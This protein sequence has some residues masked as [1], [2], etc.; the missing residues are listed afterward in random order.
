MLRDR[1]DYP[2]TTSSQAARDA[3][4]EA[5]DLFL[6]SCF[7]VE[8]AV[9]RAVEADPNLALA[10]LIA[11]RQH[12]SMGRRAEIAAPLAA[13][14]AATGLTEREASQVDALGA[15]LEGRAA[16]AM[17]KVR[18]HLAIWPRDAMIAQTAVGVFGLIGFSGQEGREAEQLAFTAALLPHYGDDWWMLG[19]HAFSQL[20]AGRLGE[21]ERNIERSLAL[22]PDSGQGA[23]I[24][25]HLYYE[26]G[27]T[28]AGYGYLRDWI[29]GYD[30]R[31]LLHTHISWHVALWALEQG[32]E[33]TLWSVTEADIA[34]GAA[35]GPALN[36]LTDVAAIL[37]RAELAGVTPPDGMWAKTSAYAASMFP[38]PGLAF[39]DLHAAL[40]HAMAGEGE[41][42]A[43]VIDGARGP[44]G[45][46]VSA[47]G[48]ALG[49]FAAGRWAEAVT[50][51]TPLMGAHERFGGSRAQRDLLEFAFAAALLRSGSAE[52]A[53]RCIAMRRRRST[54]NRAIGGLWEGAAA[55][56]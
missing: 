56:G 47:A 31:G 2:L 27:E 17:A 46:L 28:A 12:Q 18:A 10:H 16:E 51:L 55:A 44:A 9:A 42:L 22:N 34:P 30:R 52:E 49:E 4:Q 15:L 25:S 7:G 40:A 23:H 54:S 8:D 29:G 39:A 6:A 33:A 24:R 36:V 45:D 11:A 14:R 53:R 19:G 21:A 1:Y 26:N 38:K 48:V 32:D 37:F 13:A 5:M 50:L 35:S 3:C 43:R 20:E 41:A